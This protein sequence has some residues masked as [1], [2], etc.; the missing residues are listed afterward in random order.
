[1]ALSRFVLLQETGI[2][3]LDGIRYAGV[4]NGW[5][6]S[7][8]LIDKSKG[9]IK[10]KYADPEKRPWRELQALLA[11]N[12]FSTN[13]GFECISLKVGIEHLIDNFEI[14]SIWCAGLKVTANSGDQSVK[15]G[16]DFVESQ[17]WLRCDMLGE[18]WFSQLK[19]EMDGLD[20]IAK[21]LYGR[22]TGYFKEQ[23]VHDSKLAAQSTNLFWQLCERDFQTLVNSCGQ[24]ETSI[25]RRRR[26]RQGF[27][28]YAQEAYDRFCPKETA[29]QLDAWAK[30]RPNH[31]K[32]LK[33]E[34]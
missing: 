21:N 27:S 25:A 10:V 4:K 3:Y 14:F 5:V 12:F 9:D 31:S 34:A 23:L 32:Y 29:R 7:G 17:V 18:I 19:A 1:M 16:D 26:L 8:L 15:Q 20:E 24:D 6:E 28:R 11:C 2:Y 33:Q 30:C 22:V 13:S